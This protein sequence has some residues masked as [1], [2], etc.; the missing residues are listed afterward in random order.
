MS[1]A[2]ADVSPLRPLSG[3]RVLEFCQVAAGPFCGMLLA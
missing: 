1:D 2:A 3:V